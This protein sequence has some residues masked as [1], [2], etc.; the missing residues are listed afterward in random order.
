MR[1]LITSTSGAGHLQPLLPYAAALVRRGH[2]VR[3]AARDEVAAAVDRAGLHHL[4][5]PSPAPEAYQA[6]M[7]RMDAAN[8]EAA[9][10][11]G[12]QD[13]FFGLLART[14]LPGLVTVM[15]D[16]RP[17]LVL[18]ESAAPSGAVAAEALGIPHARVEVHNREIEAL[19]VSLGAG[20]VDGL[21]VTAGLAPDGGAALRAEPVFTAFPAALDGTFPELT[22]LRVRTAGVQR[23]PQDKGA[24]PLVYI[25]LGT[26][27]G[28]LPKSQAAYRMAL[29]AVADLPVRALLTTGPVMQVAD[30]GTVPANVQVE[31]FVPQAEVLARAAMVLC[32]GGSGT[33][34][35]AL[36]SGIPL[37][38]T[39]LFADQPANARSLAA[40]G[41]GLA[42]QDGTVDQLRA[43]VAQVL[44]DDA[45]ANRARDIATE[46]AALPDVDAAVGAMLALAR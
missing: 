39:P 16:W 26:V 8:A 2:D 27:A 37:V 14:M 34:L 42:V 25:T 23:L 19:F 17:D 20:A 22:P 29:A 40:S 6:V 12:I 30:L 41:A 24:L 44:A 38:I 33:M 32:H 36:A 10:V 11:I 4:I 13:F 7:A 18:R 9:R 31:T 21:R 15:R 28:R 35:G 5:L 43:A 3:V 46:I 45:F 1:I